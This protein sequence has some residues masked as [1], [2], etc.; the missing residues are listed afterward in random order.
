MQQATT[1]SILVTRDGKREKKSG[2]KEG[3]NPECI[4][5]VSQAPAR[6]AQIG[7]GDSLA[8]NVQHH[9]SSTFQLVTQAAEQVVQP[10][11]LYI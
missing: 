7:G 2:F 1:R 6:A 10:L 11:F 9:T 5:H 8:Q 3:S 4:D